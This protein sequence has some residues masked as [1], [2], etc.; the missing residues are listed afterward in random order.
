MLEGVNELK[1][2]T[3]QYSPISVSERFSIKI[4]GVDRTNFL[5]KVDINMGSYLPLGLQK[6][7]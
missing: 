7:F 4:I 6:D 1:M 5:V 2:E 3:T